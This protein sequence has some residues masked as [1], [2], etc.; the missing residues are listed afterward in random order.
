V[1]YIMPHFVLNELPIGL[2]GVFI[3]AVLAAAMSSIAAELNSLS[4]A[5]VIDFYRRWVR[6]E[7]TDTHFLNV[8]KIA[9]LGWG[10][11]ACVVA[12]FAVSLGSL[13]EVN[14]FG[15]VLLRLNPGGLPA[16]DDP[17]RDGTGGVRGAHR[18]HGRRRCRLV[19]GAVG[20]LPVA[21]RDRRGDGGGGGDAAQSWTAGD[22]RFDG[23]LIC[24]LKKPESSWLSYHLLGLPHV[25][26]LVRD[27]DPEVGADREAQQSTRR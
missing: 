21:Q 22:S 23:L 6:P 20:E 13:I 19:L 26:A 2:A 4:T 14:R 18:R 7:A 16:G 9:T 15:S 27:A 3:A 11:F 25:P 1:N 24:H 17:A 10:I 8:S 5:T 12:T